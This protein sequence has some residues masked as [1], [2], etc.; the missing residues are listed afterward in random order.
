MTS[1][2]KSSK[3]MPSFLENI[4]QQTM[5]DECKLEMIDANSPENEYEIIKPYL[6]EYKNMTYERLGSDPGTASIFNTCLKKKE[7]EYYTWA[8]TDDK[9]FPTCIEEHAKVMDRDQSIDL[10]YCRNA[11]AFDYLTSFDTLKEFNL[12]PTAK[13]SVENM[14]MCN[15]PHNHPVW[16]ESMHHDCNYFDEKTWPAVFDYEFWLRCV[17]NGKK[18]K[19]LDK[20]LGV[21]YRNPEG[22]STNEKDMN[23]NIRHVNEIKK[24]YMELYKEQPLK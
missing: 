17:F 14:L 23:R 5:F 6:K 10:V 16:R 11:T 9:I 8:N 20:V 21:Y 12:F 19:L 7:T 18:F 22:L 13:F 3:W 2:F 1:I 24:M 15:L 4:V